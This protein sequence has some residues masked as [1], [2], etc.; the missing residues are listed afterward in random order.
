MWNKN[1]TFL[2]PG[3]GN[4]CDASYYTEDRNHHMI[5]EFPENL[6]DMVGRGS[7][8]ITVD[9]DIRET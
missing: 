8:V 7:L 2:T 9:V 1:G 4:E 6:I 5:I 3:F